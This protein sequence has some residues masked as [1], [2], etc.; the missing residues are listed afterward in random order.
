MQSTLK[1]FTCLIIILVGLLAG[2][3]FAGNAHAIAE[4]TPQAPD[5]TVTG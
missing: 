1:Q 2:M 4:S 5:R 3:L